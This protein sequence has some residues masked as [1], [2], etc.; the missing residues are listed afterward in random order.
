MAQRRWLL[1]ALSLASLV[2]LTYA[3]VLTAFSVDVSAEMEAAN[4]GEVRA[5]GRAVILP[6]V[7]PSG[8]AT[9]A[10]DG[11]GALL[12]GGTKEQSF[13][14]SARN[15]SL[16]RALAYVSPGANGSYSPAT[17][18]LA[19]VTMANG[20][21]N[22]TLDVAA[23]AGGR[24]GFLVKG[25]READVRFLEREDVVGRVDHFESTGSLGLLFLS[26][27]LGFVAPLVVLI[28]THRASGRRLAPG[29]V[30]IACRECR[31]PLAKDSDF[32]MRC[33]AYRAAKEA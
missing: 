5:G 18:E 6:L 24:S 19:N 9:L 11:E 30:E 4:G 33:G 23:L 26:G 31:A 7:D 12:V 20:T 1:F 29:A 10:R 3:S 21:Q 13:P 32:C 28:A 22:L 25:D 16:G 15:V 14:A 17:I 27:G 8:V 2:V